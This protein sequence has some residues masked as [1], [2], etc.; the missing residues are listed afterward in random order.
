MIPSSSK[1]D[2]FYENYSL[3]EEVELECEIL[4]YHSDDEVFI[5]QVIVTN[6]CEQVS[7]ETGNTVYLELGGVRNKDIASSNSQFNFGVFLVTPDED[8]LIISG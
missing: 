2:E 8:H 7:C 3:S 5:K 4:A 1:K 6:F